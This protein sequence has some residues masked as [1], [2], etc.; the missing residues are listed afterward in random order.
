NGA[1]LFDSLLVFENYP[2]STDQA[3]AANTTGLRLTDRGGYERTNYP[4]TIVVVPDR[5]LMI[6]M[7]FDERLFAKDAIERIASQLQH[8]LQEFRRASDAMLGDMSLCSP[9]ELRA[10]S[11]RGTGADAKIPPLP[12]RERFRRQ[13]AANPLK[14]AVTFETPDGEVQ[15]IDYQTLDDESDSIA[16]SLR[17]RYGIGRGNRVGVLLERTPTM[18]AA[19]LGAMKAEAAYV[20][21]DR[22]FPAS[23]L[24]YIM[25]DSQ[26]DLLIHDDAAVDADVPCWN[27]SRSLAANRENEEPPALRSSVNGDSSRTDVG[28]ADLAYVIYTSGS[29]GKPKGVAITHA[30]LA[31]F[32]AAM[33]R[34]PGLDARDKLLAVTTISFDIAALELFLPLVV[35]AEIVLATTESTRDGYQLRRLIDV[36]QVSIMQATPATWRLLIA[37]E[38]AAAAS[39]GE[40]G[41]RVAPA[42]MLCGGE[43]LDADLASDLLATGG[44]LW[45]MYGPTETTIWSGALRITEQQA[46]SRSVPFGGP[47]LNTRFAVLDQIRRCVP[48]GA[49]GELHI[50][51]DG[52]SPGYWRRPKLTTERFVDGWYATGDLVRLRADGLFDFVARKD[53]Q[54][55]IRGYRIELGE[56]ESALQEHPSVEQAIVVANRETCAAFLRLSTCDIPAADPSALRTH[57][58]DRLPSY[59]IPSRFEFLDAFPLTVS[60]KIDRKALASKVLDLGSAPEDE[61]PFAS[62]YEELIAGIW[63]DVLARPVQRSDDFFEIGGHS[64]AAM[65]VVSRIRQILSIDVELRTLFENPVL[66]EFAASLSP[67]AQRPISIPRL[68]EQV[69]EIPLS[70]AQRRQWMMAEL[71]PGNALYSIPTAVRIRGRLCVNALRSSLEQAAA[72]HD[73]LRMRFHETL[74]EPYATL[75]DDSD[76]T[77]EC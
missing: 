64:L 66:G 42:K 2:V 7:R 4:L 52:L 76:V 61:A 55:K 28:A 44:Q 17:E 18:V 30:N 73:V 21:L 23:R 70:A 65:R 22:E 35:G 77:I 57:L 3:L 9:S 5:E 11:Q 36:H 34:S 59:M 40:P 51:G 24:R 16:D 63:S 27:I 67:G 19:L 41:T 69:S 20:P 10:I 49:I 38:Q 29:T 15:R 60:G 72:K 50:G 26:L 39:G 45:N 62:S 31:N 33:E 1:P 32:L 48:V 12:I 6:S 37:S 68:P 58:R 8:V 46:A 54:V 53:H 75:P 43:A 47:I 25:E 74:G 56:I 13:A 14:T 71:L